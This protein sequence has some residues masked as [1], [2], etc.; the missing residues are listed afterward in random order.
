[1]LEFDKT[2]RGAKFFDGHFPNLVKELGSIANEL[3]RANDL[4]ER[5]LSLLEGETVRK[6]D[7]G[8]ATTDRKRSFFSKI[9]KEDLTNGALFIL[10]HQNAPHELLY[11]ANEELWSLGSP[12]DRDIILGGLS[13]TEMLRILNL[14]YE[15]SPVTNQEVKEPSTGESITPIDIRDGNMFLNLSDRGLYKTVKGTNL[16]C[17]DLVDASGDYLYKGL[18]VN[19]MVTELNENFKLVL[20][21][22]SVYE[23]IETG[24]NFTLC[25]SY[26]NESL[27]FLV[28]DHMNRATTELSE[29][30]MIGYL[31]RNFKPVV[32]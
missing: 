31:K 15:R 19:D 27:W 17:W 26:A 4:K 5:E 10:R 13:E 28:D 23:S 30:D 29:S 18:S 16:N 25:K 7:V 8:V 20:K 22:R 32:E 1:M 9:T 3:K 24:D 6:V 11:D 12:D 14:Y 2:V 21:D